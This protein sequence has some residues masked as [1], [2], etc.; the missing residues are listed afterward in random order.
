M[1]VLCITPTALGLRRFV[2]ADLAPTV[3]P[4][5]ASIIQATTTPSPHNPGGPFNIRPRKREA[6]EGQAARQ[7]EA[8]TVSLSALSVGKWNVCVCVCVLADLIP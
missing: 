6:T 2:P 1:C 4:N 8:W 5:R 7:G 3:P